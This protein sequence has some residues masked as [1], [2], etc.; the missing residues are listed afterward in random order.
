MTAPLLSIL[1]PYTLDR[2]YE[3]DNLY[4]RLITLGVNTEKYKGVVEEISDFAGK[5]MTIGEKRERMYK[6]ANGVYSWQIDCDDDISDDSIERILEAIKFSL[7]L[8]KPISCITFQEAVSING[9][10]YKS[11]HSLSYPDW[12]GDGSKE[13]SDWFHFHRTPFMKSVILTDIAKSIPIP[14][15]RWG[16]DHQWSQAIKPYLKN[17]IHIESD[18]YLYNHISTNPTERYGLDRE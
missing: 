6:C 17:E 11:N 15:I 1:I 18:I 4:Q 14:Y 13:L 9:V 7:S 12:E 2:Q 8:S 10:K 3:Y 5:D 16:E